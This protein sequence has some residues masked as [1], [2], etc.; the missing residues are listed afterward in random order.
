MLPSLLA[1]TAALFF[2]ASSNA[3]SLDS[4]GLLA[5]HQHIAARH[6]PAK[7]A[8]VSAR[9]K[10]RNSSSTPHATSTAPPAPSSSHAPPSSSSGKAGKIGLAWAMGPTTSLP[11]FITNKVST[12]VDFFLFSSFPYLFSPGYTLG[13]LRYKETLMDWNSFQCY[14]AANQIESKNSRQLSSPVMHLLF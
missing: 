10:K 6:A 12:F 1:I 5:R 8:S 3:L 7:R 2:I 4:S 9:C 11:N 14:G 13:T